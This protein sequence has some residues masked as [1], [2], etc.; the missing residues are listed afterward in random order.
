VYLKQSTSEKYQE[1]YEEKFS[2]SS[3]NNKSLSKPFLNMALQQVMGPDLKL[4]LKITISSK[5]EMG[6]KTNLFSEIANLFRPKM[7]KF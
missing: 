6:I 4:N 5:N 1:G 7:M 2:V 3:C